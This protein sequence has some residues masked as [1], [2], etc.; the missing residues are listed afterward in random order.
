MPLKYKTFADVSINLSHSSD[1]EDLGV[2]PDP[3]SHRVGYS[4]QAVVLG[5]R[6]APNQRVSEGKFSYPATLG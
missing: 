2:A 4:T 3:L 6:S 5:G 1:K